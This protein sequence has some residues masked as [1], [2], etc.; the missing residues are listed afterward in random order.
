M[1]PA[2][3]VGL[4]TYCAHLGSP[5]DHPLLDEKIATSST[6]FEVTRH[7][8]ADWAAQQIVECAWDRAPPRFLLGYRDD[9]Y[10]ARFD[11]RVRAAS[12]INAA[13]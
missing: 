9:R 3:A 11:R 1:T 2:T 6:P 7:P 4:R 13:V 12:A 10:G 8:T 5:G